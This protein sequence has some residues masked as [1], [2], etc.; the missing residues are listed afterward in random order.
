MPSLWFIPVRLKPVETHIRADRRLAF[1]VLTAWGA[2]G[3]DGK[4][5]SEV[6]EEAGDRKLIRFRTQVRGW[7]STKT[8]STTEWVRVEEPEHIHFEGHCGPLPVLRDHFALEAWGDCTSLR[9]ESTFATHG[10]IL[11]WIVSKIYVQ[12]LLQRFMREHSIELKQTIE[13]RAD[14]SRTLPTPPC[15]HEE[16]G[17]DESIATIR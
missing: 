10:S 1:Q 6:L 15:P 8:N 17:V 14:R 16:A 5:V 13:A 3:P 12:P 9:Y 2:K 11:G 4:P 7:F